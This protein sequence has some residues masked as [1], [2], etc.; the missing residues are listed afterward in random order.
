MDK[1]VVP[2]GDKGYNLAF[3]V[4]DDL[5]AVKIITDY[6]IKL[7]MWEPG[8]PTLIIDGDCLIDNAV[9]GTCHYVIGAD[10]MVTPGRYV[11]ELELTAG[12]IIESTEPFF[13]IIQESG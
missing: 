10:D 13:I 12:N 2:K 9:L 11:A 3:S 8:N 4:V 5:A 6:T 7:K 1:L